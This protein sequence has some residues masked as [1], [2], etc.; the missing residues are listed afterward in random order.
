MH[1]PSP[2]LAYV[3][4]LQ[5]D[6]CKKRVTEKARSQKL[7]Q[8]EASESALKSHLFFLPAH[9]CRSGENVRCSEVIYAGAPVL[10]NNNFCM[11]LSPVRGGWG[12]FKMKIHKFSCGPACPPSLKPKVREVNLSDKAQDFKES[13][14]FSKSAHNVR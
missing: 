10:T 9:V 11:R 12:K 1:V 2:A 13:I 5:I 4:E 3:F 14:V 7:A 8:A 6:H